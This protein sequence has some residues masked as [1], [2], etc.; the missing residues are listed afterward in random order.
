LA[1]QNGEEDELRLL[2]T[3]QDFNRIADSIREAR[4]DLGTVAGDPEGIGPGDANPAGARVFGFVDESFE[5][6]EG[7]GGGGFV[8]EACAVDTLAQAR[9]LAHTMRCAQ[10]LALVDVR[11]EKAD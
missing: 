5:A 7:A 11:H 10:A 8:D 3:A 9:N 6:F 4:G 1:A 2:L